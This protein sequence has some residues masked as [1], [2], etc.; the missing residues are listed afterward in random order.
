MTGG[1]PDGGIPFNLTAKFAIRQAMKNTFAE[2]IRLANRVG[3]Q[4]V[5]GGVESQSIMGPLERARRSKKNLVS[6]IEGRPNVEF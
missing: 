5:S 6:K 4:D 3:V 1:V 2:G